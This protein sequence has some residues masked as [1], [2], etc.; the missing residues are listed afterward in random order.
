MGAIAWSRSRAMLSG[1]PS[2]RKRWKVPSARAPRVPAGGRDRVVEEP[3]DV[4][5]LAERQE[6][7]EGP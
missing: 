6:A 5:R 2:A 1:S 3:G 7:L 4:V